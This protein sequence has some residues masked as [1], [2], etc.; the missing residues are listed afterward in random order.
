M[1]EL[2]AQA[3]DISMHERGPVQ[4]NIP[5]D[6]FY[7]ESNHI[8]RSP[9]KLEHGAGGEYN[10]SEAVKLIASAKNPVILAGGGVSMGNAVDEVR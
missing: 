8:I 5:R 10:L 2:T 6:F 1:S 9:K 3:F 4:I 7:G